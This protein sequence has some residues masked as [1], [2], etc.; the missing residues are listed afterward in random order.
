MPIQKQSYKSFANPKL[1]VEY[2]FS[3]ILSKSLDSN[4]HSALEDAVYNI[5]RV[6]VMWTLESPPQYKGL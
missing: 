6:F 4:A 2:Q 3:K 5:K 1:H